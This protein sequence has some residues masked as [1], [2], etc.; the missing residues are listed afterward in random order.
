M[1]QTISIIKKVK[2]MSTAVSLTATGT[3][4]PHGITCHPAEVTFPLL[5]PP[6][7]TKLELH[8][9]GMLMMSR[10]AKFYFKF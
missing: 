8:K 5:P 3:C 1:M 10:L 9:L 4:V 7:Y 6:N 2:L